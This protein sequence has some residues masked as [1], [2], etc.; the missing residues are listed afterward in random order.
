ME[1]E[2][3]LAGNMGE[4][5]TPLVTC[6]SQRPQRSQ[7]RQHCQSYHP[8]EHHGMEWRQTRDSKQPRW[9][10]CEFLYG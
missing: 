2:N 1:M 9:A 10:H 5:K 3:T 4:S 8:P 6:G 7:S